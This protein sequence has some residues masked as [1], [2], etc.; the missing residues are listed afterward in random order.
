MRFTPVIII[1]CMFLCAF[2]CARDNL[3]DP[4]DIKGFKI[5]D[6][7]G[8]PIGEVGSSSDD[9]IL[10]NSFDPPFMNFF[11]FN[12][13]HSLD[14]TTEATIHAPVGYPNP[15]AGL[16]YY[17]FNASD[18]VLL[19][20]VV[21]DQYR[22]LLKQVGYKFKGNFTISIDYSDRSVYPNLYA[23]RVYYS[24]SAAGKP[25]FK[26]GYGDIKV[27]DASAGGNYTSCF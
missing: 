13:G 22:V 11:N 16:Q 18:S 24:F 26:V 10:Y 1:A 12:S 19:K 27:C 9:W 25:N 15:F 2:Q 6:A 8:N 20:V 14:N 4:I 3:A 7:L 5:V 23:M 21:I 17:S